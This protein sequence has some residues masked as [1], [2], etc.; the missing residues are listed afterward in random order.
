MIY[1]C[2]LSP[3]KLPKL[4]ENNSRLAAK[5]LRKIFSLGDTDVFVPPFPLRHW[6]QPTLHGGG[7][8]VIDT[9]PVHLQVKTA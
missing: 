1:A 6:C 8:Q 2:G 4:T 7:Q 3:L 5:L 9:A